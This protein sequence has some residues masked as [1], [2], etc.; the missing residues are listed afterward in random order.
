MNHLQP[1]ELQVSRYTS[2]VSGKHH[3]HHT[4]DTVNNGNMS[5][6]NFQHPGLNVKKNVVSK[7]TK[8]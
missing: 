6:G 5:M 8:I 1:H 3:Q 7:G 4:E 2:P